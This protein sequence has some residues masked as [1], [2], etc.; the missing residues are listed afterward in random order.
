MPSCEKLH[1]ISQVTK[2]AC[3]LVCDTLFAATELCAIF[4][5]ERVGARVGTAFKK[6]F[7]ARGVTL[8][9]CVGNL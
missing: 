7:W 5:A 8:L 1:K 4:L 6:L 9:Q 2:G 3:Q